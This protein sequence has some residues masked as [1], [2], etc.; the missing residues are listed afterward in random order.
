MK[1]TNQIIVVVL[2]I[3]LLLLGIGYAAIQNITLNIEGIV[4][5]DP[6]QSN[7]KVKYTGTPKVSDNTYVTA[8]I[9]DDINATITVNGLT[10]KGQTVSSEYTVHMEVTQKNGWKERRIL[11]ESIEIRKVFLAE[12]N[13]I[14]R[15][16]LVIR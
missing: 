3:A 4:T 12:K 1:K 8:G 5:A 7:F 15:L 9:T 10:E 13:P 16:G 11:P 6:S 14:V 2:I